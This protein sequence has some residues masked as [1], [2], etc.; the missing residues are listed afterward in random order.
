MGFRKFS[1]LSSKPKEDLTIWRL[2]SIEIFVF[3]TDISTFHHNPVSAFFMQCVAFFCPQAY[4]SFVRKKQ[5]GQL[6]FFID[7]K[8]LFKKVRAI[9]VGS[10]LSSHM[11]GFFV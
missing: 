6:F 7:D 5:V 1:F 9:V 2:F 10:R 4:K 8:L 3:I 11:L